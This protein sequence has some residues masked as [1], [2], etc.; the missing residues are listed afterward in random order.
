MAFKYINPGYVA[1]LDSNASASAQIVDRKKSKTGVAFNQIFSDIGI[2]LPDFVAGDEFWG[3]FD[4][5]VQSPYSGNST[6]IYFNLPNTNS[7][8]F[9][10]YY[11][12]SSTSTISISHRYD[13]N[14][15][16]TLISGRFEIVGFKWKA[17]NTV[18][19]HAILGDSSTAKL[20]LW[21]GDNKFVSTGRA[22]AYST[23]YAKKAILYANAYNVAFS[24]IIFSDKPISPKEQTLALPI[25]ATETDMA[26]GD[27]GIYIADAANQTL[28]QSV[29]VSS[30]IENF[31]ASSAI[32]G[33]QLV[34]N[35]AYKTAEGLAH[36]TAL[37][38][39]DNVITEHKS[40]S[41]SDDTNAVIAGGWKVENMTIADLQDMRLG[42]KVGE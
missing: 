7:R 21:V 30:L 4:F 20:E 35:P 8:G 23:S 34:G 9:Y 39:A 27:D 14:N 29:D 42:W 5:F 15:H 22:M 12:S 33:I 17:I 1:L 18:T 2:T 10:I 6:E 28:L 41:L 16:I 19:F 37:S 36:L 11:P 38:K 26:L 40:F 31:G 24:N 3:K 25:S 13:G 32:T